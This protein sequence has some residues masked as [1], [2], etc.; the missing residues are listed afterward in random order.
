M[1]SQNV[2]HGVLSNIASTLRSTS[3]DVD[4]LA[5]SLPRTPD[6][7]NG[8][9]A[10]VAIL[11]KLTDHAGQLVVG[12]AAAAE[13]VASNNETYAENDRSSAET[14]TRSGGKVV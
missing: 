3:S 11:S 7:G 1:T 10:I 13:T 4:G 8:T 12:A 2:D 14:I 6:A 9:A 5:N